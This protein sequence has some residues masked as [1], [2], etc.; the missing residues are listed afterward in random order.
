MLYRIVHQL[1]IIP[2]TPFLIP[3]RASRGHNMRF[4]IPQLT[5]N[6]QLYSFFPSTIPAYMEPV[7]SPTVSAPSLETFRDRLPSDT[8][9]MLE[10]LE[11]ENLEARRNKRQLTM[12][13]KSLFVLNKPIGSSVSNRIGKLSICLHET[14]RGF[15][16][17][18]CSKQ[19][20]FSVWFRFQTGFMIYSKYIVWYK[21][22]HHGDHSNQNSL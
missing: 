10:H 13:F 20:G 3:A 12:L 5:V 1:V 11:W 8:T 19:T 2:V 16:G 9:S 14:E 15:I 18:V 17:P 22:G 4:L 7:P 6:G 21:L